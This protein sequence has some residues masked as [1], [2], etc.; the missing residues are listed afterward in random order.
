MRQCPL[1]ERAESAQSRTVIHNQRS[2]G[3]QISSHVMFCDG[4]SQWYEPSFSS[5]PP[6]QDLGISADQAAN[7]SHQP[8]SS[9]TPSMAT[10]CA[11]RCYLCSACSLIQTLRPKESIALISS[12]PSSERTRSLISSS[13]PSHP[14]TDSKAPVISICKRFQTVLAVFISV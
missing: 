14:S 7:Q 5:S 6:H 3:D 10:R 2:I 13:T 11:I 9:P 4:Q 8:T 1:S 12:Y